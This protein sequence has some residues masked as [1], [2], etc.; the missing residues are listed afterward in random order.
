MKLLIHILIICC[1]LPVSAQNLIKNGHFDNGVSD[2]KFRVDNKKKGNERL[3]ATFE[4]YEKP[5]AKSHKKCA[6]VRI[7]SPDSRE[8]HEAVNISQKLEG[9]K[10]GK[11][12]KFSAHV[13]SNIGKDDEILFQVYSGF[14][15]GSKSPYCQYYSNKKKFRGDGK[16]HIVDFVFKVT[17]QKEGQK[18][19]I[20]NIDLR[21]GFG[22]RMGSF[23]IDS[24]KVE[25]I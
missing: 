12:Y 24:V 23:Y 13:R 22:G 17:P 9:L 16:W 11:E 18:G 14:G 20:K 3:K 19:D 1:F 21:I 25:R 7:I 2:W 6:K 8:R 5:T 4:A 10:K 15:S